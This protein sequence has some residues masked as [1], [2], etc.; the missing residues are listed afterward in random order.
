MAESKSSKACGNCRE[1]FHPMSNAQDGALCG[2][3]KVN[4]IVQRD[5][6]DDAI[7]NE[8]VRSYE[9]IAGPRVGDFI[10]FANGE[11]RRIS[12]VWDADWHDDGIAR[13]QTSKEGIGFYLGNGYVSFSGSLYTSLR[14][15]T[16]TPKEMRHG[17]VWIFH[18]DLHRAG[19]AVHAKV[20]FRVFAS[21]EEPPV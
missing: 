3:C 19:G 21:N 7:L 14:A 16:L 17:L 12:H 18:H 6:R 9:Q 4:G 5:E 10:D 13:L 15:D 8:R 1:P 11:T 20:Q 2:R